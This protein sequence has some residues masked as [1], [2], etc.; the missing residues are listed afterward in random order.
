MSTNI[1]GKWKLLRNM[2]IS[3]HRDENVVSHL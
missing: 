3:G 1:E 2:N